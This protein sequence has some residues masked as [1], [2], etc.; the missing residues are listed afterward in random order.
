MDLIF[1]WITD[2]KNLNQMTWIK[3]FMDYIEYL[4]IKVDRLSNE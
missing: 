1:T 2:W 4:E 3:S